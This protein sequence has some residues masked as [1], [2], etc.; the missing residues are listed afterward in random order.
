MT[1]TTSM[2]AAAKGNHRF[3]L[4]MRGFSEAEKSMLT[5]TFRLTS[6]R[7][8]SYV[9]PEAGDTRADIYLINADNPDALQDLARRDI[10][11]PNAHSPAVVVGRSAVETPWPFVPKP[12]HWMRLFEKLDEV[13][14]Q[15]LKERDRRAQQAATQWD[16]TSMRRSS[17]QKRKPVPVSEPVALRESVLV[18]D[19]SAT[20]RA[21]MRIKLSPFQF[22]VDFA[23]TGEEAIEKANQKNYT[24]IFLDIMMPGIDGYEVCKRIKGNAKTKST[25]VVMLTSKSSMIDKFRGSWS[26]CNAY[27]SKP[28][29]EDELLA[30]IAKFLPSALESIRD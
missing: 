26:G 12:I 11:V 29:V 22:D 17:D 28:V 16:G 15:A 8:M 30:T 4:E 25:A 6:R 9:E 13:M 24:C 27:L 19:D 7:A 21:F 23:E 10:G 14:E 18:V 2:V 20:V 1:Q 5:S 3:I